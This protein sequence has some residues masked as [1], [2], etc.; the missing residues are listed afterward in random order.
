MSGGEQLRDY[1]A[2][3]TMAERLVQL[4][5]MAVNPGV[6]NVCSGE[7]VSVRRLV[8][9]WLATNSWNIALELGRY[10]YPAHEPLAFWGDRRKLDRCIGLQ[11]QN[12][13]NGFSQDT[14]SARIHDAA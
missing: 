10:E 5:T 7:P 14:A 3:E 1:L 13:H 8:D 12:E 9:G 11:D 2:V 4:A 6:V